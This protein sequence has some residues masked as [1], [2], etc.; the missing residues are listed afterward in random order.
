[1][2]LFLITRPQIYIFKA[3]DGI[4]KKSAKLIS[5]A[6]IYITLVDVD[7]IAFTFKDK[8]K[9]T[10]PFGYQFLTL[11]HLLILTSFGGLI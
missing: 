9:T 4:T 11:M 2:I 5:D 10:I 1:M 6:K 7:S 8:A 3:I